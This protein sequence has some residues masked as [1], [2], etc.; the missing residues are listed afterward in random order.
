MSDDKINFILSGH[1]AALS[2]FIPEVI[3]NNENIK[4]FVKG[5]L[6]KFKILSINLKTEEAS[7]TSIIIAKKITYANTLIT[8]SMLLSTD[9]VKI[10]FL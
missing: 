9:A 5:I 10:F 8:D 4:G 2:F 7:H 6:L 1:P 3:S